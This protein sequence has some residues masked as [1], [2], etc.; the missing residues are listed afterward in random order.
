[1]PDKY[2]FLL[3]GDK[4]E[5]ELFGTVRRAKLQFRDAVSDDSNMWMSRGL[6]AGRTRRRS[7]GFSMNAAANEG[8]D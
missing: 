1:L 8:M 7:T 2:R 4:R 6:K 3:F 5:V